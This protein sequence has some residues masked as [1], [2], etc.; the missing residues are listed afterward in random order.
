MR[1]DVARI[2]TLVGEAFGAT[3]G[4]AALMDSGRTNPERLQR[5]LEETAAAFEQST[6]ELRRLCEKHVPGAGGYGRKPAAPRMEIAGYVEQ[7]GYGWLHMQL[8]T[9]LPHCRYQPPEWLSNTIHR[10][11]DGYEAGGKKLPFFNR[12]MLV[13]DEHYGIDGRHF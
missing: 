10:L 4:L 12:A 6:L 3:G 13:I 11:L 7:F 2:Q 5:A 8:N 1:K 9:L